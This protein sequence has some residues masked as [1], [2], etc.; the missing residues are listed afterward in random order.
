MT[1]NSDKPTEETNSTQ[2]RG[3]TTWWKLFTSDFRARFNISE[4]SAPQAEVIEA[5]NKGIFFRGATLWILIFATIVACVGLNIN[6]IGPIIGAMLIS[7]LMGPILGFGLSLA[8]ND[9]EMMKKSVRNFSY[10]TL[11]AIATAT[12]YFV[13]TPIGTA[14]S[15]LLARTT[16]T[17]YDVLV[18]FFGGAAGVVGYTR[19]ERALYVITGV[20]IATALLPP[21]CTAGY[22]LATFRWKFLGGALYLFF[23]NAIFIAVST[24][25][26]I[27]I[28]KYKKKTFVEPQTER[29]VKRL[30]WGIIVI[31]VLPSIFIAFRLIDRSVFESN[32]ERFVTTEFQFDNTRVLEK[33]SEYVLNVNKKNRTISV[34]LY[35]EPLSDD[36]IEN[37]RRK[38]TA[39][40]LAHT[41]LV[42]KQSSGTTQIDFTPLQM[43]YAQVLD[44]K[45]R[46]IS[47]LERQLARTSTA[48]SI[49]TREMVREFGAIVAGTAQVS[50]SRQPVYSPQGTIT[51][52]VFVCILKPTVPLTTED[53]ERVERW[54]KVKGGTEKVKI[55][56][57]QQ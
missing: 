14:Q 22:G 50:L 13:L 42:V 48:D 25:V 6:S 9:F 43:G 26:C 35:G 55:Y 32:A 39:Y 12:L 1:E 7:P 56:V 41:D 37:I 8:I 18:A 4:D 23:I 45:N 33:S 52:T 49:A 51:D 46:Q 57:E 38:M 16:P 53:M 15:E 40:D 47:N 17:F 3:A 20:A 5:I 21:L 29:R 54:M 30:M 44:E 24:Y 19:K 10:M 2:K 28:L 11:T 31:A 36:A 27:R 34:V